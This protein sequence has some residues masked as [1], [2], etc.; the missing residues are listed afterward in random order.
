MK[1]NCTHRWRDLACITALVVL[2]GCASARYPA[3]SEEGHPKLSGTGFDAVYLDDENDP[4]SYQRFAVA[5][6][7][8]VFRDHWLRE[9]NRK[10]GPRDRV[11]AEH[12]RRIERELA[13][14]CRKIFTEELMVLTDTPSSTSS[15]EEV[16][17]LQ[18]SIVDLDIAAP[19]ILTPGRERS[20][21]TSA[22][23][24][25]LR[26]EFVD[27]STGA[28]LG[29]IIDR[30]SGADTGRVYQATSLSNKAE[31][32]RILRSWAS[33]LVDFL[34]SEEVSPTGPLGLWAP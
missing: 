19:D 34:K 29:R 9:Q 33:Q 28:V 23:R 12:M 24:M 6:C 8:V 32:D 13:A 10:R 20:Y 7:T 30:R 11:T 16:L 31:T 1:M 5:P 14:E 22:G 25:T 18:P 17:M 4:R 2:A 15:E 26:L 21:T 3:V 27:A